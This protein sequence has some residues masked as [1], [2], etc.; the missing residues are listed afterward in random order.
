[1]SSPELP[2]PEIIRVSDALALHAVD[3]R[4]VSALYQSVQKNKAWLQQTM[5]WPQFVN[6]EA[7]TRQTILSNVMLHQRGYAKMFLIFR[8]GEMLGVMSFNLI[9][10]LNK[11]GYLGYWLDE[12]EQ[13][14]GTLSACLQAFIDYYAARG[15]VRRFV[16]KC[17]VDN[18]R[19]NQVALRNGFTFEGCLRQAEYLN[20]EYHDQNI[21]A[22]IVSQ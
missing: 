21:Y 4:F 19:S 8:E 10:P 22:R 3:E 12:D 1:M 2:E 7:D 9:E 17:R 6:S 5:N 14:K 15:E 16:I 13:G 18:A 20:G 11:T